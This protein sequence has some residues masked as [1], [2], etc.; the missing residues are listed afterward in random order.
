[1]FEAN[2]DDVVGAFL[3]AKNPNS[4]VKN[5]LKKEKSSSAIARLAKDFK[6]AA[7]SNRPEALK[8]F[9]SR[10][11]SGNEEIF[12]AIARYAHIEFV[13]S[14]VEEIISKY[15]DRFNATYEK[16]EAGINVTDKKG[17]SS[18]VKEVATLVES[19]LKKSE[20]PVTEFMKQSVIGYVFEE[21]VKAAVLQELSGKA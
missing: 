12:L 6:V 10:N 16:K 13:S 14:T 11:L 18:I 1:M 20:L 17:F 8:E 21:D 7:A 4:A 2:V 9:V 3:A 15:A 5:F 19:G